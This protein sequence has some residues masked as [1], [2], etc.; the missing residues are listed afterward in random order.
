VKRGSGE[1]AREANVFGLY[2]AK[3]CDEQTPDRS[4]DDQSLSLFHIDF[5]FLWVVFFVET[6]SFLTS[7]ATRENN[8][9]LES[10]VGYDPP[11]FSLR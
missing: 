9:L 2:P 5:L 7:M 6:L 3:A 4:A 11:C 10:R 8:L 1:F